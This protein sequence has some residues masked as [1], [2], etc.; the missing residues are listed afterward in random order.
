M[1]QKKT[2]VTLEDLLR[3][4]RAERPP[5]EFWQEF[6]REMRLKELAAIVEP[7][8]WWA[9]FIKV[10]ARISRYQLPIGAAAIL[11][12]SVVTVREYRTSEYGPSDFPLPNSVPTAGV[13]V[14][15]SAKPE[16]VSTLAVTKELATVAPAVPAV[17]AAQL[18][19]RSHMTPVVTTQRVMSD[20]Q[21]SSD[22]PITASLA[23][24]Q[25]TDSRVL[26]RVLGSAVRATE[27]SRPVSD[28]LAQMS[29]PTESRR[30]RLLSSSLPSANVVPVS[31]GTSDRVAS[32][33]TDE[34]IYDRIGRLDRDGNR[35]VIK[36]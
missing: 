24:A 3:V 22:R 7:R 34:Q 2:T 18:G 31:V 32:R 20:D 21:T 1:N 5:V 10:G 6:E 16:A 12:L 11:A 4:K 28:P 9:S 29:P 26:D 36:F 25:N 14:N 19:E 30:S 8:P 27:V 13:V 15:T 33:L 17:S 35:L 23:L